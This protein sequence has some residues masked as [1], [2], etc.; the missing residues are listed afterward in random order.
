MDMRIQTSDSFTEERR[1]FRVMANL[2]SSSMEQEVPAKAIGNTKM[3]YH[4][5]KRGFDIVCSL[6][7]LIVLS[8]LF[9]ITAIAIRIEDGGPI[10]F[11]QKRN[12]YQGKV[13]WMYK[14]RSM[15]QDA[16][17]L[18][19]TLLK[20]NEADGP[21]FKIKKDPRVT[22]VGRFIRKTSIDELP[23]LVNVLRG[24]MTI[25]GPR[26]IVT[27]ETAKMND[28][29]KQRMQVKPGLTCYWQCSG[30]NDTSF[31][32]W[33]DMDLQYIREANFWVDLKI[34][35]KTAWMVLKGTGA[36]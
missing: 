33:I 11:K 32:E 18:H 4:I 22:K 12:G 15:C 21:V 25:V 3:T 34:I 20:D 30:R 7:A 1:D 14:F 36:Y 23:Q 8:P 10:I 19:S 6:L 26:P 27:Y 35:F 24:E 31:D 13:F 9:L 17:K 5:L 16:E 28:Y 29:Q 2:A